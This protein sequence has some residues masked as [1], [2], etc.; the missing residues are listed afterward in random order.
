MA[1]RTWQTKRFGTFTIL[2]G[3]DERAFEPP[4]VKTRRLIGAALGPGGASL[5]R[6]AEMIRRHGDTSDLV[7]LLDAG[8]QRDDVARLVDSWPNHGPRTLTSVF[9]MAADV[10]RA[11]VVDPAEVVLWTHAM[12]VPSWKL[13]RRREIVDL[14][15]ARAFEYDEHGMPNRSPFIR[16]YLAA[17]G[18]ARSAL[19]A[20]AAGLTPEQAEG[21]DINDTERMAELRAAAARRGITVP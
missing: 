15:G 10:A 6:V 8:W 16:L 20:A 11:G 1:K 5:P 14:V 4:I 13:T 9:A 12:Y 17:T 7:Y 2:T 19:L 21:L 3:E 18:D